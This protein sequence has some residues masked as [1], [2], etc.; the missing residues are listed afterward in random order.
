MLFLLLQNCGKPWP[1]D[2][3]SEPTVHFSV[4][5]IKKLRH[6]KIKKILYFL[7]LAY[8]LSFLGLSSI[9]YIYSE[10][11]AGISKV[12][13][14]SIRNLYNNLIFFN[15]G[16]VGDRDGTQASASPGAK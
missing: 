2:Q 4:P 12:K 8:L 15:I 7:H 3:H 13:I 14:R 6:A 5:D 11:C 10:N 1:R 9:Q 16:E